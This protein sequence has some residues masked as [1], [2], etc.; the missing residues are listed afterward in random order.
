MYGQTAND[1]HR[2]ADVAPVNPRHTWPGYITWLLA[3]LNTPCIA[4]SCVR[5][6][7]TCPAFETPLSPPWLESDGDAFRHDT[8]SRQAR[9]LERGGCIKCDGAKKSPYYVSS[10]HVQR[11]WRVLYTILRF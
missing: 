4:V 8:A 6:A 5:S 11:C 10:R 7:N 1:R 3:S 2:G 9:T